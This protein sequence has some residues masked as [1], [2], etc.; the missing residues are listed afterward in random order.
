M[1]LGSGV[2]DAPQK[3]TRMAAA[4]YTDFIIPEGAA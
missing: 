2:E 3:S 1:R 4:T